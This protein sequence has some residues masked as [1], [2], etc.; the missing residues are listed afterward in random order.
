MINYLSKYQGPNPADWCARGYAIVDIDARGCGHS[1][2]NI[3]FWGE[4]VI[5]MTVLAVERR[6]CILNRKLPTSMTLSHGL[7]NSPGATGR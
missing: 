3:A 4:Q 7:P 2:G 6:S 5:I 1:E